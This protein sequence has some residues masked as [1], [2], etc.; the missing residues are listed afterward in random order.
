MNEYENRLDIYD[1]SKDDSA[2]ST[3]QPFSHVE[4]MRSRQS[5]I[6]HQSTVAALIVTLFFAL[7]AR[8]IQVTNR[9]ELDPSDSNLVLI[10]L[11]TIAPKKPPPPK[12]KVI[13]PPV[14]TKMPDKTP[15]VVKTRVKPAPR[16]NRVR[17]NTTKL[18]IDHNTDFFATNNS[19]IDA[20]NGPDAKDRRQAPTNDSPN[21]NAEFRAGSDHFSNGSSS[22]QLDSQNQNRIDRTALNRLNLEIKQKKDANAETNVDQEEEFSDFLNADV[23]LVL[24]SSDLSMGTEEYNIWNKINA[25]FDRWDK[26]RYGA[27]P[28]SLQRKGRA[29]IASFQY[30]DDSAHRIV[31]LRGNT[32]LYV[33]GKKHLERL[34]ELQQALSSIIHLNTQKGRL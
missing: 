6:L 7:F 29:M 12:P 24:T 4:E 26:G 1:F 10:A 16:H 28:K 21:L 33:Q 3:Q 31:W 14:V 32:K 23:S 19:S 8:H 5:R 34:E 11:K 30:A 27:L 9:F 15:D 22:L 20:L 18:K 13:P 25:E 2:E 17:P